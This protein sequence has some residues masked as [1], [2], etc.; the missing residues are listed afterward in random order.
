QNRQVDTSGTL[1]GTQFSANGAPI[2]SNLFTIDGTIMND[3]HGTGGAS[4]N[5]NTLG[6]EAIRE[7]KVVTNAFSAEYGMTMG[8]QISLVTKS[9]TNNMHGS[10]FEYFR[11]S[12]LNSRGWTDIPDKAPVR[13]NNFGGAL[14]G[15]IRKDKLFYFATYEALKQARL[16]TRFDAVP[17][18]AARVNGAFVQSLGVTNGVIASSVVPYLNLYPHANNFDDATSVAAGIGRYYYTLNP[19]QTDA[20]GQARIDYT[21]SGSDSMFGRY[22]IQDSQDHRDA[23]LK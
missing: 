1:N 18:D 14:G 7:Y 8:S 10:L 15:P 16:D 9:G 22:S 23:M 11:N 3:A 12:A 5:E 17:I 20:Y 4:G 19:H 2:R 6:V 21:I 13:R